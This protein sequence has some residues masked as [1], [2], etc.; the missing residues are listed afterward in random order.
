[1]TP[2]C[3]MKQKM[4]TARYFWRWLL[5]LMRD[6]GIKVDD[7]HLHFFLPAFGFCPDRAWWLE[8]CYLF[9]DMRK[10]VNEMP[11]AIKLKAGKRVQ[12]HCWGAQLSPRTTDPRMFCY[13]RSINLYNLLETRLYKYSYTYRL[14]RT[15]SYKGLRYLKDIALRT[16]MPPGLASQ[17]MKWFTPQDVEGFVLCHLLAL[18]LGK[19]LKWTSYHALSVAELSSGKMRN[20]LRVQRKCTQHEKK[21][22]CDKYPRILQSENLKISYFN[23]RYT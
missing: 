8:L 21:S 1:M 23:I 7:S 15:S 17:L 2:S 16:W 19:S 9:S 10:G 4:M 11:K 20:I 6:K 3:P 13:M 12:R 14:R 22:S 18:A 5:S